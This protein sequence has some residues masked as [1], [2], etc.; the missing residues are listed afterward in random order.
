MGVDVSRKSGGFTFLEILLATTIL[1]IVVAMVYSSFGAGIRSYKRVYRKSELMQEAR[2][3]LRLMEWD[4]E[5]MINA[6][7]SD[8]TFRKNKISFVATATSGEDGLKT[9]SYIFDGQ[10]M[11]RDISPFTGRKGV[12][13]KGAKGFGKTLKGSSLTVLEGVKKGRFEFYNGEMWVK[14][15]KSSQKAPV[16]VRVYIESEFEGQA[17]QFRTAFRL[18]YRKVER[19][20]DGTGKK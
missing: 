1:G 15:I 8:T 5:R 16:A 14:E 19:R 17:G 13:A 18:P 11:R 10:N 12:G 6:K 4:I 20:N 9:I 2:G 7:R 3:G